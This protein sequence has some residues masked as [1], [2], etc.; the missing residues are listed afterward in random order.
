MNKRH[1]LNHCGARI[2]RSPKFK[3]RRVARKADPCAKYAY[4]FVGE[5]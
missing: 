1:R 2:V 3:Q 5:R 4:A